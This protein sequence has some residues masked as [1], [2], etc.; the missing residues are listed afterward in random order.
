MSISQFEMSV[1]LGLNTHYFARL[2]GGEKVE[3]VQESTI[4]QIIPP[5]SRIHLMLKREKI[6]V[7]STTTRTVTVA[8]YTEV[9]RG[10]Y[11]TAAA[12]STILTVITICPFSFFA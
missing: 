4:D 11:G 5:G 10:N 2:A 7:F 12:L 8:I 3:I 9:V 6:N 1:F